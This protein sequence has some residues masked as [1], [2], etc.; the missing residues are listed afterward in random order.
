[1][2]LD[3]IE[4]VMLAKGIECACTGNDD[5][6]TIYVT[7]PNLDGWIFSLLSNVLPR[8][9][10]RVLSVANVSTIPRDVREKINYS[11]LK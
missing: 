3:D 8:V 11:A 1:M 4:Q 7:Q 6:I 5:S 2:S 10:Q 9:D